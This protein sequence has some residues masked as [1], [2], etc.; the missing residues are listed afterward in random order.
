[1]KIDKTEIKIV[2]L[3]NKLVAYKN[4][5]KVG[6]LDFCHPEDASKKRNIELLYIYVIPSLRRNGVATVLL[7]YF[8]KKFNN[9]TWI[10]LWTGKQIEKDKGVGLYK[11]FG[12]KEKYY[13]KD[14][15]EKGVGTRLFVKRIKNN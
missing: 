10:S 12:F 1:M 3:K 2:E 6:Y 5:K 14:Y 9:V 4:K 15:Y 13:Q 7:E 11:K 8:L